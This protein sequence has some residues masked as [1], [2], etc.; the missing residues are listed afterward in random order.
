MADCFDWVL[1]DAETNVYEET[2][3]MDSSCLPQF[4]GPPWTISKF[5]LRGGKQHGVD[6]VELDNGEMALAIIPTRGMNILEAVVDD[7]VL[8]WDSPVREIVHPLY[9]QEHSRGGL[10][11]LEGFNELMCR[12]GLES[13]GMPGPDTITDNQGNQST[14][15]LPLHGRISNT[16]A[17]RVWVSVE[18]A[19]PYRLTVGGE[20]NDHRMFGPSYTLRT[21]ISTA[22]GSTEF[23]IRDEIQNV[24][25]TAAEMELL[26]HCNHGTPLLGEGAR[27]VAPVKKVSARDSV[28]LAEVKQWDMYA[29]PT[30]GFVE[31]C[32]FFT[33]HSNKA[34][35]TT[36]AL[37]SPDQE[38]AAS[39]KFSTK[40]LPAF[41]L[42]KNTAGEPDGYVTGLEPGT[43]YPN[44]RQF[45]RE[46]GRVVK[47]AP[48]ESY[49]AALTLGLV[50]GKSRVKA[51]CTRIAGLAK[52]KPTE[53]CTSVDPDLS[54]A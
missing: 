53:V 43:D 21:T 9:I 28:A 4:D 13:H 27:V 11:W 23:T 40:R 41:T 48:D 54:P 49:K 17:S 36:V 44:P 29:A 33:L 38:M 30:P 45:E 46:R 6:V 1:T 15:V 19:P 32:Y 37:V 35:W 31:R 5:V 14:V 51:L 16:P 42:W 20:V 39:M 2:W 18:L 25:A 24:G 50:R 34:G 3:E 26:Y 10:A 22:P 12:C 7:M 52:G 47:L 8:G